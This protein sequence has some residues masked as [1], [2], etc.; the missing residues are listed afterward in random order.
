MGF[1]DEIAKDINWEIGTGT[2]SYLKV[3]N[4]KLQLPNPKWLNIIYLI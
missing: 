2:E 4:G 1:Y 3:V